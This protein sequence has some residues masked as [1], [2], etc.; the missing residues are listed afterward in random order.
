[1]NEYNENDNNTLGHIAIIG[2]AGRFPGANDI[3]QFWENL[4]NGVESIQFFTDEELLAEG[5][6]PEIMAQPNYV[7]AK[8]TLG[9]VSGFD[10]AFFGMSPKE[11]EITDPQ[12]RLFLEC[13]WEA[14]EN[15]GYNPYRYPGEIGVYAGVSGVNSYFTKNLM[16]NP[17]V[18]KTIG[19]Y[20]TLLSNDKDFLCTRVSYKLNLKGPSVTTQTACSTSLVAVVSACQSLLHYQC[21]IALAGGVAISLPSK[22]GYLYQEGM[23][24]SPDGH[25]RTFDVGAQG[26]VP[27]NGAGIVV[28]K[29]LEEALEEGDHIYAVI[30]GSHMNND[31][32]RKMS[33]TAPSIDGQSQAIQEAMVLANVPA[34][35]ISYIETHGTGT[36]L[37]DPIEIAALTQAFATEAKNYCAIGSVKTNIGH[38]D[39]AAG[40][41]S[42][43]KSALA[44]QHQQIPPSLHFKAPNP[45]IDFK[46]SP[47]YVNA[48]LSDWQTQDFPR[49]AGVSAFGVGGT[50]AHVVI[51]EAPEQEPS[52]SP[53]PSHLLVLSAKTATAL[54][55]QTDRLVEHFK[56]HA[57]LNVADVAYTLQTGRHAFEHRRILV[58]QTQAEAI[59]KLEQREEIP[60]TRTAKSQSSPVVFM[61]SGQ[62]SQYIG[63]GRDLY[64]TEV[65]FREHFDQCATFLH[66][67]FSLDL[68]Q[69]LYADSAD[70]S[71]L[72]Q[73]S[74]TQPALFSIEY[75]LAQLWMAWGIQPKAMIGHSIGEYVAACLSD[76]LDLETALTLITVRGQLVQS[77]QPGSMLAVSLSE[78]ALQDLLPNSLE[79]ATLNAPE[80]CVVSGTTAA[81][82]QFATELEAKNIACQHLHTSHAFHSNMLEPVLPIFLET[83]KTMTL[84]SPNI[85]YISNVTGKWITAEEATDPQYWVQHL[86]QTVRFNEGLQLLLDSLNQAVLLEIGPGRILSTFAHQNT[87]KTSEHTVLNSLRYSKEE[88]SDVT[89]LLNTLGKLWA[90]GINIKWNEFYRHEKRYR[91]PL[92]TYPFERQRYWVEP[93][94]PVFA[95]VSDKYEEKAPNMADWFY[96]PSWK[97]ADLVNPGNLFDAQTTWVIF[98]DE[99]G[100][101]EQLIQTLEARSQLVIQVKQ[102]A[103]FAVHENHYTVNPKNQNDYI[104][105]VNHLLTTYTHFP[106]QIIH[107]WQITTTETLLPTQQALEQTKY[108]GFYSLVFLTQA[109][110]AKNVTT[111]VFMHIV[112]NGLQSVTGEEILHPE[113]GLLLG[114]CKVI[115]QEYPNIACHSIDI[116]W[117]TKFSKFA[118]T[119]LVDCLTTKNNEVTAYR[120]NHR[121]TQVFEPISG[122]R[123]DRQFLKENG[124]YLITGGLGN[125]GLA[126]ATMFAETTPIKLMLTGRSTFPAKSEWKA[127]LETHDENDATSQKIK[128]LQA[129]E[130]LGSEIFVITADVA[131]LQQ[132][133]T[134][135]VQ[136]EEQCGQLRGVVHAAGD[137]GSSS[138]ATIREVTEENC[139]QQFQAKVYGTLNLEILLQ[140]KSLDFCVLFSSLSAIFGGFGF[141][142]YA[143]VNTFMDTLT[144]FHNK[145]SHTT[146]WTTVNWDRWWF[147]NQQHQTF[148]STNLPM[149][150]LD[151]TSKEGAEVFQR[152]MTFGQ[153][154]QIVT[155]TGNLDVRIKQFSKIEAK[156]LNY[157]ADEDD[158]AH[159]NALETM[160]S[161]AWCQFLGLNQ[162]GVH[163]DFFDLG[164]SSLLA[165]QLLAKLRNTLQIDLPP[166]IL[167][168]CPTIS[169]LV[170]FIEKK[171]V[172]EQKLPSILVNIQTGAS[173]H[174]PLFLVHPVGGHVY[175][176]RHL[177]TALG[178]VYPVYGLQAQGVDGKLP[179]ITSIEEMVEQYIS[180]LKTVQP[181]GPYRLGGASFG[182]TVAFEMAQTLHRQGE[183]VSLLAMIDTPSPQ[184]LIVPF[185][186][187]V[188]ILAYLLDLGDS[189]DTSSKEFEQL[190]GKEAQLEYFLKHSEVAQ[191]LGTNTNLEQLQH[192]LHLF[193][194][195]VQT[196]LNY[197]P[198][199]IFP[200]TIHFFRAKERDAV[201]PQHPEQGWFQ[202]A[203]KVNVYEI[204]GN[205]ATIN[206]PPHITKVAVHL[207]NCLENL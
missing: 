56:Q 22:S 62:G 12:Q 205:H 27:G 136:I 24:L 40:V 13:A 5:I 33:Y 145:I 131:N 193:K 71:V 55:A 16:Q 77:L 184:Q 10:A 25:C 138:Y 42:L 20:Q 129:I 157:I 196:L 63:I 74:M 2:M 26:I 180:A 177:A 91:L 115:P 103:Q 174:P 119:L 102:G 7:K 99:V 18:M 105:L 100:V 60:T 51:E 175:F 47:F 61:F 93:G 150:E 15:A 109:L 123:Q 207:K 135:L 31:G 160:L 72:Q 19:D 202:L 182:G 142:S 148:I 117:P 170:K 195:N 128:K 83:V 112:S 194:S 168:T 120:G 152:L 78:Q 178:R 36:S 167:L 173:L 14:L 52:S 85:P 185:K 35:T 199:T 190:S 163:D 161:D 44:L 49:R 197:A 149:S 21:D 1:M 192:F 82:Q 92:P 106:Q 34:E 9:D 159:H 87:A 84:H 191:E 137:I 96:V 156:L 104:Q 151:M 171:Q 68:H 116:S 203:E 23:I 166:H 176:Y 11:A 108:P 155:S 130:S 66:A 80:Q 187:D 58:C 126:V 133:Q 139:E 88:I 79:L 201:N 124:V 198:K 64:Q 46:N 132:M 206:Y 45:E 179:P 53:R 153:V 32:S 43:I 134:A 172:D 110:G 122:E 59:Q 144:A 147:D 73:T 183:K 186:S 65:V 39:S 200:G 54:E 67:R 125:I 69:L 75:A 97:R 86:R 165:V 140:N 90:A 81:I 89:F 41:T 141:M 98:T 118:D 204:S 114:P 37:G 95:K 164:G 162:V 70:A 107:L 30:R 29:R 188:D 76:V 181:E 38:L 101:S 113:K 169:K 189:V 154:E 94:E 146:F 28:L 143:A 4:K 8:G 50:N 127:W 57:D 121:W 111:P 158:T 6:S 3:E 17:T 48:T